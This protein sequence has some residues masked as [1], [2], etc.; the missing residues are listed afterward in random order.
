[1]RTDRKGIVAF[2]LGVVVALSWL[3]V[4]SPRRATYAP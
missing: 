3:A 1:M 2:T 4:R